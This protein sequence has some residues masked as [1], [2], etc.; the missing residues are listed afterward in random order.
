MNM[1]GGPCPPPVSAA[2]SAR[3]TWGL[4]DPTTAAIVTPA[5]KIAVMPG[6][7]IGKEV[8]PEGLK[9]LKETSRKFGFRYATTDYP[10]GGEHYL[11]TK[12]TLPDSALKELAAHDAI[13]FGAVGV[14]PRGSAQIPQG[15]LETEILLKMRF[16]LDQYIN[17]RPTKLLPGVPTPLKNVGPGDIDMIIVRENTEGL[18]C[19]N[20]GFLYKNTPHEVAN[21]IEVTTRRGVERAIRYAFEYAKKFDRKKVTLVAKT[22]VLRFAHNLWIRAFEQVKTEYPGIETDYHH[23]DA[24]TMYMVTKPKIYDVIVTTNMFG[25]IITDLGAAIQGGM[26]MAASGNLNPTRQAASMFE[27]VHGSAPDIAG[28]GYANPIATFLSVAMMLDFL[29][30]SDAASAIQRAC[31]A[32][33]ADPKNHTRDLGGT[34]STGQVGDAVLAKLQS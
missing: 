5:M 23:V 18:Y 14:D 19:G 25:D 4:K 17:L 32:V 16:E 9:V 28:K 24:C 13:L 20:G 7:G 2:G 12:Q 22:N 15:I 29:G 33:V 8:I 26:G 10:F 31:Q 6:D 1:Q 30:Q 21:Q 34:A 27:P 11:K 3:P